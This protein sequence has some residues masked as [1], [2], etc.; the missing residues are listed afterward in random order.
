MVVSEESG[1]KEFDI[2]GGDKMKYQVS[3]CIT[4]NMSAKKDRKKGL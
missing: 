4:L 1:L 3:K 2:K